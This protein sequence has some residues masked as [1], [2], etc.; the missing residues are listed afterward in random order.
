[1]I[2]GVRV[3]VAL[4]RPPREHAVIGVIVEA[5]DEAAAQLLAC[6]IAAT[7]PAV[8]MPVSSEVVSVVL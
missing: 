5:E 4:S 8:V 6:Q 2:V 7:H 3:G 1:M